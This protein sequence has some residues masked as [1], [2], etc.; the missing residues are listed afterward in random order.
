M[1][2]RPAE[3]RETS[4]SLKLTE[5]FHLL[6]ARRRR[7]L[8]RFICDLDPDETVS[9][10]E[11]AKEIA[12]IENDTTPSQVRN[13][14]YRTCYNAL[15]QQHLPALDEAAIVTYDSDRQYIS[16]AHNSTAARVTLEV[17]TSPI[18]RLFLNQNG[19]GDDS[20]V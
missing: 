11:I 5:V 9:V 18:L 13:K 12:A 7:E 19:C 2:D 10:R 4:A 3:E 20:P 16:R 14:Q 15:C 6:Q 8:I 1:T 17:A